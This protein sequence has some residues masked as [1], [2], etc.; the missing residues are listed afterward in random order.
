MYVLIIRIGGGPTHDQVF[1]RDVFIAVVA[2]LVVLDCALLGDRCGL[3]NLLLVKD[4]LVTGLC[5]MGG[6][7]TIHSFCLVNLY[8]GAAR[9]FPFLIPPPPPRAS[10]LFGAIN[11]PLLGGGLFGVVYCY[12]RQLEGPRQS[13]GVHHPNSRAHTK[14]WKSMMTMSKKM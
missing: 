7:N 11:I 5:Q 14:V 1:G 4:D 2:I 9:K 6:Y 13:G 3:D 10:M 8:A 12:Q